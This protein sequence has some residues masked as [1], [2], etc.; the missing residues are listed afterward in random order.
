MMP[1]QTSK[2]YIYLLFREYISIT[3]LVLTKSMSILQ[4]HLSNYYADF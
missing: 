2:H 4:R 1:N 3:N